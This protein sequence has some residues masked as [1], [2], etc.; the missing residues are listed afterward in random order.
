MIVKVV[1]T[2]TQLLC[3][4]EG[5]ENKIANIITYGLRN[6]SPTRLQIE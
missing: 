6:I 5:T 4:L 3:G 1:L 2:N